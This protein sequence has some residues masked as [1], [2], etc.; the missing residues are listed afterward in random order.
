MKGAGNPRW[1]HVLLLLLWTTVGFVLRFANLTGK[2][3]WTDEFSTLVFSLGNSFLGVPLDQVITVDE[4]LQPL[5]PSPEAGIGSVIQNLFSES[6]HPPLYFVL[7]H[8]WLKLFPTSPQ[9]FV[10]V[11][12]ARS[13]AALFGV[14]AI[15]ATFGLAWLGFRS[16]TV[17]HIAAALMAVSPFGVYLAQ[18]ARHYTLPI[19]WILASLSCLMVAARILRDR[20]MLP[21]G[22]CITWIL[23]NGL[24]I[25]THYFF[26]FTLA[27]EA[28]VIVSLG[29]VQSW[30]ERG[31]WHPLTHW[32][33]VWLVAVGTLASGL[34]WW[35]VLQNIQ[36]GELTRWIYQGDRSGMDWLEPLGQALAGW[37]TMLYLLPIQATSQPVVILS[38]LVLVGLVFWTV[39]QIYR[40]LRVQYAWRQTRIA[41][42]VLSAFV[43]AAVL[44]FFGVT[45][46]FDTAL[47]SAFRYNFVYFPAAIV[48]IGAGLASSWNAA[49]Q[50][51]QTPATSIP[52]ALLSLIRISNRRAVIVIG[53]CSFLGALTV[54]SNLGYQKTHRPDLVASAIRQR[55]A[56]TVLV[57][58][59]HETHG[60]TGRLMGIAWDLRHAPLSPA[61]SEPLFLL[62]QNTGTPRSVLAVLRQA[63]NRLPRPLDLWLI[64]FHQ[65]PQSQLNMVLEQQQCTAQ[66]K[67]QSTDGYRY[68]LYQCQQRPP[69]AKPPVNRSP[70]N[71]QNS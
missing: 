2:P 22:I 8:L 17:A 6:N 46:F 11:W 24:G 65:L 57:A 13:L 28:I 29:L 20:A 4:L 54:I 7:S 10:S 42:L 1:L 64:N 69:R 34:V 52:L 30:R 38:A 43:V 50:I 15:P 67:T 60:Q 37:I 35:P 39:P 40:G 61:T 58:I 3:L 21:M 47:T 5:R 25:A 27:A 49:R 55:S 66:T 45:Y 16:L 18:E 62:A 71:R 9:G 70:A 53:V 31:I 51:A 56:E 59:P 14:L 63:L 48:L 32:R 23:V 12:A 19:L 41:V 26:V 44:L 68:R 36:G 33:R